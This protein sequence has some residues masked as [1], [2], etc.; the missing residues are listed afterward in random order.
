MS[1][2][3]NVLNSINT[4]LTFNTTNNFITIEPSN[5][6][7]LSDI[8]GRISRLQT[9]ASK[10]S[11]N[12][13]NKNTNNEIF[14]NLL[15]NGTVT[16]NSISIGNDIIS[17]SNKLKL[18]NIN[19][20]SRPIL[21]IIDDLSK[22][23]T[24][25]T[26]L[27]NRLDIS[28]ISDNALSSYLNDNSGVLFTDYEKSSDISLIYN[29]DQNI[30]NILISNTEFVKYILVLDFSGSTNILRYEISNNIL[31]VDEYIY[32]ADI[33]IYDLINTQDPTQTENLGEIPF[34]LLYR[35][36]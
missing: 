8:S 6:D 4:N 24:S 36:E 30:K 27:P 16:I 2:P 22:I 13:L 34:Y 14:G 28:Y 17:L 26:N 23:D 11:N 21:D 19:P 3:L 31:L 10:I 12:Y 20:S 25:Y 29:I 33:D 15:V 5:I 35:H 1:I 7:F 18:F 32:F 9:L